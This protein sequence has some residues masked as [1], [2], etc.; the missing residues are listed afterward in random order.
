[1]KEA[2]LI[3]GMIKT[4]QHG[5]ASD[6]ILIWGENLTTLQLISN[7]YD[8]KVQMIYVDPPYNSCQVFD[9]FNDNLESSKWKN[10][11]RKRLEI[12]WSLLAESGSIW[13]SIDDSEFANL[14]VLCDELWGQD[15][16]LA[17]IVRQKNKYPSSPERPIVHMHDYILVYAKNPRYVKLNDLSKQNSKAFWDLASKEWIPENLLVRIEKADEKKEQYVYGIEGPLGDVIYPPKGRCWSVTFDEYKALCDEHKI[18]FDDS[19]GFPKV[20]R[21]TKGLRPTSL[22][23]EAEVDSNQEARSEIFKY[24]KQRAFYVPKPERLLFRII[25]ISTDPGDL[26]L[27]PYLGSGTTAAVAQMM[28]RRWIGI[29]QQEKQVKEICIPRLKDIIEGNTKSK[30]AHMVGWESGGGFSCY[31]IGTDT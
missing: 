1:M 22:W 10:D 15:R 31:E 24:D 18:W 29:E 26:V 17:T 19:T 9:M 23:S 12:L 13:I 20:K 3:S 28:R 6:N 27:D 21:Y 8:K 25:A 11:M 4:A 14:R 5:D 30:I 16:F 7:R 2:S